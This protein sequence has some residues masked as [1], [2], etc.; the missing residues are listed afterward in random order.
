MRIFG[1][2]QPGDT[3]RLA[4][5]ACVE[6]DANGWARLMLKTPVIDEELAARYDEE[7]EDCV[8]QTVFLMH[9]ELQRS[10]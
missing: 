9:P 7:I 6:S 1:G 5:F 8:P 10:P 4:G 2:L 3:W